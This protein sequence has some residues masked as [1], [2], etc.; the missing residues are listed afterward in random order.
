MRYMM[1]MNTPRA[2]GDYQINDWSPEDFK[3]QTASPHYQSPS[4]FPARSGFMAFYSCRRCS[5]LK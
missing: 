5:R 3:A 1:M 2:T 4:L